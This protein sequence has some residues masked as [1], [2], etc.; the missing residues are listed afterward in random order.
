MKVRVNHGY[1][2]LF[3]FSLIWYLPLYLRQ[4]KT[5]KLPFKY[6][7]L[8]IFLGM[9]PVFIVSVAVQVLWGLLSSRL[10][11]AGWA[12]YVFD[13]FLTAALT[14]ELFKYAAALFVIKK[15]KPKRM[16]DYALLFG[17]VG[18]GFGLTESAIGVI[19]VANA[20]FSSIMAFHLFWQYFMGLEYYEYKKRAPGG[21]IHLVLALLVPFLM[22][23]MNDFFAF[24]L[25]DIM[26]L[27][28]LDDLSAVT[29]L[30]ALVWIV[31]FLVFIIYILIRLNKAV[32]E[33][34]EKL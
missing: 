25:T 3:Y 18:L 11:L 22:H 4:G 19:N 30:G 28:Q 6:C 34:R 5:D 13:A 24:S 17:G 7:L 12:K 33:S 31:V 21:K 14:E 15:A 9:V 29:I 1:C 16:I 27:K 8:A 23:G 26:K 32:K 20:I 10:G 2:S